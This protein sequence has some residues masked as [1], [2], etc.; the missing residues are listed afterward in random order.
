MPDASSSS[1]RTIGV[2]VAI[3]RQPFWLGTVD[4]AQQLCFR[5]TERQ[6]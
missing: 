5:K 1:R 3:V 4:G 6:A 2:L